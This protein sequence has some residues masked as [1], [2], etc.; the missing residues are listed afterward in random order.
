M[1]DASNEKCPAQQSSE[2]LQ[3]IDTFISPDDEQ[4]SVPRKKNV[5]GRRDS[6]TNYMLYYLADMEVELVALSLLSTT[7]RLNGD[8]M[9]G[10]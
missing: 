2:A 6:R 5:G 10:E 9:K 1:N 4:V 3:V 7:T 8:L